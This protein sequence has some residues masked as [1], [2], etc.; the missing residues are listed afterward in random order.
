MRRVTPMLILIVVTGA[1]AW[2]QAADDSKPAVSNLPG[3]E[4]P[5]VHS[6]LRVTFRVSAPNAKKVQVVP[7]GSDNGLGQGPFD[8]QRDDKGV[9][10]VTIPPAVPGFHYY[11]LLVDGFAC[12]DPATQTYFGWNKECSGIDVPDKTLDFYD[13]KNVLHGEVRAHWYYSKRTAMW[14]RAMVYTPPDYDKNAQG[15]Y[16][17]LYLQHG[18]GENERG[19]T[20]QGRANFILDNLIAQKK[21]QPMIVV[22]EN[23]MV[24]PRAGGCPAAA[25]PGANTRRNEAF[26]ELVVNDLIP[27]VDANYRT[28]PDRTHRAIAG[29]SMGAGQAMQIGLGNLD[30]F[31]Y[32][33]SFSGVGTAGSDF[34]TFE[35]KPLLIWMGAGSAES[36]R[37]TSGKATVE[38]ITKAGIPAVWF[39]APGT[40]HEWQT[41]RKCLYDLAPRLFQK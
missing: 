5:R 37:M 31:A 17:V 8:M 2:A 24:A 28:I 14:R 19:W 20:A 18:R 21:A 38:A 23:G 40:S 7:G 3:A 33:G 34:S 15:R 22:M 12:N 39:E 35:P 11:W 6:D 26:G 29:L 9:W 36:S 27:I 16:P 25:K 30:K 41:W 13:L 32:V 10:T 4:Y 1:V